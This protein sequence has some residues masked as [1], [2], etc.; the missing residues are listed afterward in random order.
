MTSTSRPSAGR[1]SLFAGALGIA[2]LVAGTQ[3]G[4][5]ATRQPETL[6]GAIAA[7][8]AG[9]C[10]GCVKP[11]SSAATARRG[12]AELSITDP[13]GGGY[14]SLTGYTGT[15][16]REFAGYQNDVPYP[17]KLPARIWVCVDDSPTNIRSGPG[18]GYRVIRKVTSPVKLPAN[19]VRVT[20]AS[21]GTRAGVAWYRVTTAGRYG[22]VASFRVAN[23]MGC[24]FW[25]QF[26]DSG[27]TH[28][29]S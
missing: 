10:P 23:S 4:Q 17:T 18:V 27:A 22:W 26:W 3:S 28:A 20:T 11:S 1:T 7:A 12:L 9:S 16:W 19:K 21:S 25:E 29:N 8:T 2:A 14:M 6:A 5:A 15:R 24:G 13:S